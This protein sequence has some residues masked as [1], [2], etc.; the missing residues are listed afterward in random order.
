MVMLACIPFTF[1]WFLPGDL[2]NFSESLISTSLFYSNL[3]F[4]KESGYF[5]VASELKPLLHTWS[6]AL[7]EQFYVLFPIFMILLWKSGKNLVYLAL[8]FIFVISFSLS[9]WGAYN[10]PTATFYFT[11]NKRYGNCFWEY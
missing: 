11:P 7:E 5:D 6:L 10:H 8:I 2:K 1:F 3:L 4:W 9:H